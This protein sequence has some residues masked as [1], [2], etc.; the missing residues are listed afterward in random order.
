[1][2]GQAQAY[3]LHYE[4]LDF[5]LFPVAAS[6]TVALGGIFLAWL[7]YGWRPLKKGD[8][9][10]LQ[11]WLGPVH[12]VLKNKYYVDEFYHATVVRFARWFADMCYTFDDRWFIDPIVDGVGRMGRWLADALR[13][14]IDEPVI[15]G[16]VNGL[17]L[18]TQAAGS[19]VRLLQTGQAQNYLLVLLLT[20]LVLLAMVQ[21]V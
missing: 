4:V 9:D 5:H 8:P 3:G 10:P 20:V 13:R 17:G 11:V 16:A 15:D 18:V 7:V 21:F 19:V 6:M 12:T 2:G 1:M 14:F